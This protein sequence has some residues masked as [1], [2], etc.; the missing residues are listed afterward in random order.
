MSARFSSCWSLLAALLIAGGLTSAALAQTP[1]LPIGPKGKGVPQTAPAPAPAPLLPPRI[2]TDPLLL[3]EEQSLEHGDRP[4]AAPP[5]SPLP[6]R[7]I[8]D[9]GTPSCAAP[10]DEVALRC[11]LF[12]LNPLSVFI[13]MQTGAT[14]PELIGMPCEVERLRVMPVVV[15][16]LDVMPAE[17]ESEPKYELLGPWTDQARVFHILPWSR[18]EVTV[19]V[20]AEK[21][22]APQCGVGTGGRFTEGDGY[23]VYVGYGM[24]P[25]GQCPE[26]S[27]GN[28]TNY[29]KYVVWV[30]EPTG[31]YEVIEGHT[32]L[33]HLKEAPIRIEVANTRIA[34]QTTLGPATELLLQGVGV[35]STSLGLWFGDRN[36]AAKQTKLAIKVKVL[37]DPDQKR[38]MEEIYKALQ[39]EINRAFPDAYVRLDL[40]GEKLVVSGEVK[41]AAGADRI[42]RVLARGYG[43]PQA[44]PQVN[45]RT[46]SKIVNLLRTPAERQVQL[47]VTLASMNHDTA[48]KLGLV[49]TGKQQKT[50]PGTNPCCG[51]RES[52]PP[53]ILDGGQISQQIEALREKKLAKTLAEPTL[54]TL[55]GSPAVFFSG[56]TLGP[57][58]VGI[59]LSLV[60]VLAKRDRIGLTVNATVSSGGGSE[61]DE[62]QEISSHTR[63]PR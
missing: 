11:L 13:P 1:D 26:V 27:P 25:F 19:G 47:K 52:D 54:V 36:D 63:M 37:P 9:C 61:K 29:K 8:R 35:G 60:P 20:Q 18:A 49:A 46:D 40:V 10:P 59:N 51:P 17:E 56:S 62:A 12:S 55:N 15:E 16:T 6:P 34:E 23:K 22:E 42:M 48:R 14:E 50:G 7:I 4:H 38:R 21:T 53:T 32:S 44:A 2:F 45:R 5:T 58:P 28:L 24:C 39:D 3:E 43:A 30:D 31:T 41:D 33:L 57:L